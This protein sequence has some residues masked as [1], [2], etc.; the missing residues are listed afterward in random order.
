MT[1]LSKQPEMY[2]LVNP[3]TAKSSLTIN[4]IKKYCKQLNTN[5]IEV[6]DRLDNIILYESF[7]EYDKRYI[8]K[9]DIS[10]IDLKLS[11]EDLLKHGN[12]IMSSIFEALL[13]DAIDRSIEFFESTNTEEWSSILTKYKTEAL[14]LDQDTDLMLDTLNTL[15]STVHSIYSGLEISKIN[16]LKKKYNF[17]KLD[18]IDGTKFNFS[19]LNL[20][21]SN[22]SD[23]ITRRNLF[24]DAIT[25]RDM[26]CLNLNLEPEKYKPNVEFK[27]K[28]LKAIEIIDFQIQNRADNSRP[29][30]PN[31]DNVEVKEENPDT[32]S[33]TQSKD[34]DFTTKRQVL[35]MYYLLNE[36]D[37]NTNSI[38]RT[39][40]ARFIHFLT[41]KNESN[42]YKT[43]ADPLKGLENKTNKKSIFKDLEFIIEHFDNLGLHSISQKIMKDMQEA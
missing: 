31:N 28:C 13:S 2:K 15:F 27:K 30:T 11:K 10:L 32:D 38:D 43:F 37:K 20:F 18:D 17:I 7:N 23:I 16:E 9:R 25:E 21:I 6:M 19:F 36:L 1:N 22:E 35:A 3:L 29:P 24:F 34:K 14:K 12:S 42:I 41:G 33:E 8:Q 5:L 26:Y 39:V 40:K 4:E